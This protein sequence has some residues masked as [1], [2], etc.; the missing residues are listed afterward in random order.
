M[1]RK[2]SKTKKNY[3]IKGYGFPVIVD[4]IELDDPLG[5]G[6]WVPRINEVKLGHAVFEAL[7]ISPIRFTG[8]HIS[9]IRKF[10]N[11]TQEDF[12]MALGLLNHGAV[13]KWERKS[14]DFAGMKPGTEV[15]IKAIMRERLGHR[16]FPIADIKAIAA[17]EE[18][19]VKPIR[20]HLVA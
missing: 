3:L 12:A 11:M 17:E 4:E 1:A 5:D 2:K 7:A 19:E 8:T 9:F 6:D 10:M 14:S 18:G 13:S 16:E 20:L 15:L